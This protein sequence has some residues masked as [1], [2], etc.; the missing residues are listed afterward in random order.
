[1]AILSKRVITEIVRCIVLD[2]E[3]AHKYDD[4]RERLILTVDEIMSE[5]E[6]HGVGCVELPP[7]AFAQGD[8]AGE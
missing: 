7:N 5:L 8:G 4:E 6:A 1:M 3:K 2:A